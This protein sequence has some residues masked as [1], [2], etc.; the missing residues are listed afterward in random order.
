MQKSIKN[1]VIK[2]NL[3]KLKTI[4]LSYESEDG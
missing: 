4:W 1:T 2:I 3:I